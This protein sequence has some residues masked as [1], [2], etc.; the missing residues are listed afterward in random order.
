MIKDGLGEGEWGPFGTD[1]DDTTFLFVAHR[2]PESYKWKIPPLD[3]DLLGGVGAY[4][5]PT[6]KGD[7]TFENLLFLSLGEDW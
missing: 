2:R 3:D 5:S 6:R 4:D 1:P 7:D